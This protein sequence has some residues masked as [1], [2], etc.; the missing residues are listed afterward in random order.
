MQVR[1]ATYVLLTPAFLIEHYVRQRKASYA[2]AVEFNLGRSDVNNALKRHGI[3]M[4]SASESKV[5]AWS[6]NLPGHK[7]CCACKKD[8]PTDQFHRSVRGR[9]GLASFC[10][11]CTAKRMKKYGPA[12]TSDRRIVKAQLLANYFHNRCADCGAFNL[13][14]DAYA[15]H[16]H[17]ETMGSDT[18]RQPGGVLSSLN[19]ELIL[20]ELPKWTMLCLNCHGIR[21]GCGETAEQLLQGAPDRPASKINVEV[22]RAQEA[23]VG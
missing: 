10:R 14:V 9:N 19:W 1:S 23:L 12:K 15:F 13:P 21:H 17:S 18:Y 3:T 5:P 7:W 8:L 16:H 11:T 6:E 2:I 20:S 4:R 22:V